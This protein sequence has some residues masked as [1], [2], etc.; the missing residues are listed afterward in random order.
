MAARALAGEGGT[1][2]LSAGGGGGGKALTCR[3]CRRELAF[4]DQEPSLLLQH[5]ALPGAPASSAPPKPT[6]RMPGLASSCRSDA[7]RFRSS[8]FSARTSTGASRRLDRRTPGRRAAPGRC[9]AIVHNAMT[10]QL[11]GALAGGKHDGWVHAAAAAA[12]A[13]SLGVRQL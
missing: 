12:A 5:A 2:A 11:I 3:P 13:A 7:V 1:G 9:G 8:V 10:A 6:S 4:E